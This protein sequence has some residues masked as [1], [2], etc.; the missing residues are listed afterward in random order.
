MIVAHV[1]LVLPH[2]VLTAAKPI[3]VPGRSEH[4]TYAKIRAGLNSPIHF[5]VQC[6]RRAHVHT[7]TNEI[8][9]PDHN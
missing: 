8:G 3:P 1:L 4:A 7:L 2:L 5:D 9:T 6:T